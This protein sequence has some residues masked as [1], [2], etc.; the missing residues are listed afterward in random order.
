[1]FVRK[2]DRL[3]SYYYPLV[4]WE[5]QSKSRRKVY[6]GTA[7]L[8]DRDSNLLRRCVIESRKTS[9]FRHLSADQQHTQGNA[10]W[11]TSFSLLHL[12]IL[13]Y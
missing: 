6:V 4:L 9:V 12:L 8:G 5:S 10:H 1:M 11:V 13:I 3:I 2:H 7:G